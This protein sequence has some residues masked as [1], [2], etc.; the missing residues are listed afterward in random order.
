LTAYIKEARVTAANINAKTVYTTA[1][2]FFTKLVVMGNPGPWIESNSTADNAAVVRRNVWIGIGGE[3]VAGQST[4]HSALCAAGNGNS[5]P[6]NLGKGKRTAHTIWH[7]YL[8][9]TLGSNPTFYNTATIID[10]DKMGVVRSAG[11]YKAVGDYLN[12]GAYPTQRTVELNQIYKKQ[13]YYIGDHFTG[14][15]GYNAMQRGETIPSNGGP[16]HITSWEKSVKPYLPQ[17][18]TSN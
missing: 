2:A 9:E 11:W 8:E 17:Y 3:T 10:V 13:G 6:G 12:V 4:Q 18:N 5:N 16:K 7:A 1:S 14:E 15:M